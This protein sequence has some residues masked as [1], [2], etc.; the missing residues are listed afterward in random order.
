MSYV[1]VT[2]IM[3]SNIVKLKFFKK[4]TN[5]NGIKIKIKESTKIEGEISPSYFIHRDLNT[6]FYHGLRILCILGAM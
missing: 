5:K 1:C 2:L 6:G 4:K 3:D